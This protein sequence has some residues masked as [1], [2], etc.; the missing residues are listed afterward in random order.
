MA[1][2]AVSEAGVQTIV[3]WTAGRYDLLPEQDPQKM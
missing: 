2:F 1:R 3:D